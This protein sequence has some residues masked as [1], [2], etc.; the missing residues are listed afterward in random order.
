MTHKLIILLCIC[1]WSY[2]GFAQSG[3]PL[4]PDDHLVALSYNKPLKRQPKRLKE[5]M[6]YLQTGRAVNI[7]ARMAIG[8]DVA[9]N[10]NTAEYLNYGEKLM[11]TYHAKAPLYLEYS[12]ND[13]VFLQ[14]GGFVGMMVNS[15]NV[16]ETEFVDLRYLDAIGLRMEGGIVIGVGYKLGKGGKWLLRYNHGLTEIVPLQMGETIKNRIIEMGISIQI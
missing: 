8:A 1:W 16:Y 11:E 12:F 14:G 13:Q 15:N 10:K 6:F 7:N 4:I 9:L 5:P 3:G 2:K